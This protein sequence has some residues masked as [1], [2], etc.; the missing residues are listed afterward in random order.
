[1]R[2]NYRYEALRC[3]HS[4][5]FLSF[6]KDLKENFS[7]KD[8]NLDSIKES[9]KIIHEKCIKLEV[10]S[11]DPINEEL[12]KSIGVYKNY[13]LFKNV[14]RCFADILEYN[15]NNCKKLNKVDVQDF[16]VFLIKKCQENILTPALIKNNL[17]IF[18]K[19]FYD[20]IVNKKVKI[21]EIKSEHL[22]RKLRLNNNTTTVCMISK[23]LQ[24]LEELFEKTSIDKKE[25]NKK[26]SELDEIVLRNG[27]GKC[28]KC[29][30]TL[31]DEDISIDHISPKSLS[32]QANGQL[33]CK[34]CNMQKSNNIEVCG[35]KITALF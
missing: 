14:C 25:K 4:I 15:N 9:A 6:G 5:L 12:F 18:N 22:E 28:V 29:G 33:M 10:R 26:I 23:R 32:S 1:L 20:F 3:I 30:K 19:L 21:D 24:M 7:L 8:M 17:N 27:D 34:K 2:N 16:L 35:P 13:L 11:D 31:I